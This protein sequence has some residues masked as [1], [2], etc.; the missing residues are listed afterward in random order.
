MDN[1]YPLDR[2]Y[3]GL[4]YIYIFV[5]I[6]PSV[7]VNQAFAFYLIICAMFKLWAFSNSTNVHI[8]I[9]NNMIM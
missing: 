5:L 8:L 2:T 3:Q 1:K 6:I 4:V 9:R 7:V